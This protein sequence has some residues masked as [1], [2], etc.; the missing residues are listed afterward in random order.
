MDDDYSIGYIPIQQP[1]SINLTESI[2]ES[3][4]KKLPFCNQ[5]NMPCYVF[6]FIK[7]TPV[8][9]Y[10]LRILDRLGNLIKND[11][12]LNPLNSN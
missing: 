4:V 10:Y 2:T 7:N 6:C 1:T 9:D 12:R 5:T 3:I 11:F 8:L